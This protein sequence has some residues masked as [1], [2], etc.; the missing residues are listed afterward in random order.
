MNHDAGA[1]TDPAVVHLHLHRGIGWGLY[2]TATAV[3]FVFV[4]LGVVANLQSGRLVMAAVLA[5]VGLA[6]TGFLALMTHSMVVPTLT[7]SAT[8]PAPARSGSASARNRSAPGRGSVSPSSSSWW[9]AR[10]RRCRRCSACSR[11]D[12]RR[13][14]PTLGSGAEEA[15]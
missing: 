14:C 13:D 1:S 10:R 2:G 5:V 11:P 4:L 9:R 7:V 8:R 15:V 12:N 6:M 3:V